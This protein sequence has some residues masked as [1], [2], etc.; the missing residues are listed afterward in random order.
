MQSKKKRTYG[1]VGVKREPVKEK[2]K[3]S[4]NKIVITIISVLLALIIIFGITLGIIFGVRSAR[5]VF[6]YE[7]VT[8]N[9]EEVNYLSSYYKY[10][11]IRALNKSGIK[12][13]DKPEFWNSEYKDGVTYAQ[14]L[15]DSTEAY[16]REIV[17]ANYLFDTYSAL[18]EQDRYNI[19]KTLA[20][21]LSLKAGNSIETFNSECAKYGFDYKTFESIVEK[22]Y[23]ASRVRSVV[24]GD[25]GEKLYGFPEEC[26]EYLN[27]YSHV[28]LLFIRT[29]DKFLLDEKGNRVPNEFGADTL[30]PLTDAEKAERAQNISKINAAIAAYQ[31]GGDAA[32]SPTMFNNYLATIDEG[33]PSMRN[34]GYYFKRE[35]AF[36][37]EF[38]GK[39]PEIVEKALSMKIGSYATVK[40][41]EWVCYIYKYD[42]TPGAYTDTT[43]GG[44]FSDFYPLAAEVIFDELMA[45][46][47]PGVKV[48]DKFYEVDLVNL[49]YNYTFIPKF[50]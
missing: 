4:K 42:V 23:K 38:A 33:D 16:I 11:F 31:N 29:E 14:M 46:L 49:P 2:K 24:Y 22:L 17:I 37:K 28:K 20:D 5:A 48:K 7:G 26:N 19:E 41:D 9:K 35:T 34:V 21:I 36:T 47:T 13:E 15:R 30:V 8:L 27:T 18:A 1:N 6:S 3:P 40:S 25:N 50:S 39:Y 10:E 43:P 44:C 45:E 32:M 12:A